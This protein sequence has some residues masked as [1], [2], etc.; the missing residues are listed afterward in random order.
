L[1]NFAFNSDCKSEY[2]GFRIA[3]PEEQGRAKEQGRELKLREEKRREEKRKE[4]AAQ[5]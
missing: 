1:R 2:S 4:G 3:N 5:V